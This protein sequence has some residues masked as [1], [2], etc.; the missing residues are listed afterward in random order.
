MGD[1]AANVAISGK[2]NTNL[3]FAQLA[4]RKAHI[5]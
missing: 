5:E 3:N 4:L 1:L 2:N